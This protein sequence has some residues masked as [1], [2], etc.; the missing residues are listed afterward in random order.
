MAVAYVSF[1]INRRGLMIFVCDLFIVL[2]YILLIVN[3]NV[4]MAYVSLFL[5][6]PGIYAS[7]ALVLSLPGENISGQTKRSVAL[8]IMISVG[9]MGS[10]TSTLIYRPSLNAHLFR[11]PNIIALCYTLAGGFWA[12]GI[13]WWCSRQNTL[14]A[15]QGFVVERLTPQEQRD[16]AI[17]LGDR[18]VEFRYQL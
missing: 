17:E 1:K 9:N 6:T 8:G 13:A 5:I 2:G 16:R 12:L 11:T 4:A 7:N 3:K 15:A 18:A 14:R 10:V